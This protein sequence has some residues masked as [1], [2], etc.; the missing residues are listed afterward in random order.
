MRRTPLAA[1]TLLTLAFLVAPAGA[2]EAAEPTIDELIEELGAESWQVRTEASEALVDAGEPA[3]ARLRSVAE[4]QDPEVRRRVHEILRILTEEPKS[5]LQK[6][7][8]GNLPE[9]LRKTVADQ[10]VAINVSSLSIPA[11]TSLLAAIGQVKIETSEAVRRSTATVSLAGETRSLGEALEMS[12]GPAGIVYT[13]RNGS[14][15]LATAEE[16]LTDASTIGIL[17]ESLAS[18]EPDLRRRAYSLLRLVTTC[19]LPYR[20]MATDEEE[21]ARGLADWRAWHEENGGR[22]HWNAETSRFEVLDN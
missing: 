8:A 11:F 10:P 3:I 16:I 7:L 1:A 6:V 22:L 20:P 12:L 13:S 15:Y 18:A 2:Q 14:L 21:R 17:I 19:R 9:E 4:H 5:H